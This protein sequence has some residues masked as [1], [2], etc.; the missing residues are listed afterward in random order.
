MPA[1]GGIIFVV[2]CLMFNIFAIAIFLEGTGIIEVYPFKKEYKYFFSFALVVMVLLYYLYKGRYKRI[3]D[4][5]EQKIDGYSQLHPIFVISFI[6][7]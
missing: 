4:D 3:V 7:Q 6:M 1:L 5:Y 2:V